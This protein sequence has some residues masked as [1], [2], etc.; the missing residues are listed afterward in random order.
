VS[1]DIPIERT[2]GARPVADAPVDALVARAEE[3]ARR[4]A[5]SLVAARP[6]SQMTGVPLDE[7]ARE[8]PELCAQLV[9]ALGSDA[10][11]A[12]MLEPPA[13]REPGG[14]GGVD[15]LAAWI[16]PAGDVTSAVRDV[17]ALRGVVWDATLG[18]LSEPSARQVADLSDR[19]AF[20]CASLLGAV[21][22]RNAPAGGGAGV[23]QAPGGPERAGR[24][25]VL[26]TSP[27]S[28]PSGRRAV[29]IDERGEAR[30]VPARA[31]AAP[32]PTGD[33]V[34]EPSFAGARAER[35]ATSPEPA[36]T[37]P[38]Q[39][40][41]RARPWDTPLNAGREAPGVGPPDEAT[42]PTAASEGA[43]PVLRVTRGPGSRVD[44]RA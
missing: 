44:G 29:L 39:T 20:T 22:A 32:P 10:E 5:I 9:R 31:G 14:A 8:A 16:A 42:Q 19:L 24:E 7:L 34:A 35:Q 18:E 12:R 1:R 41:P 26:Y 21:L 11:L 28:S 4:W 17:E 23:A 6:L 36:G 33:R 15:A 38:T 3:L 30:S 25:Q 40:V 27:Q 37:A 2:G 43:D 13:S